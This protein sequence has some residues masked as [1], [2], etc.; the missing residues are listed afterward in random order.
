MATARL[1]VAATA[2]LADVRS[3]GTVFLGEASSVA[4]GDYS[5][6]ANHDHCY[7]GRLKRRKNCIVFHVL[8]LHPYVP[9]GSC[10]FSVQRD[11]LVWTAPRTDKMTDHD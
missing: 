5:T 7:L 2:A 1:R 3:A 11:A 10:V 9:T 4:F 8:R 6:G